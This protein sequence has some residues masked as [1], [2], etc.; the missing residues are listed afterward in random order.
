IMRALCTLCKSLLIC[1]TTSTVTSTHF[2]MI[3]RSVENGGREISQPPQL[4]PSVGLFQRWTEE[5]EG[6]EHIVTYSSFK[7]LSKQRAISRPARVFFDNGKCMFCPGSG[8]K[9]AQA[10]SALILPAAFAD[11]SIAKG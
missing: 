8:T 1:F 11:I 2:L 4:P 9:R 5:S 10:G 7:A 6:N 3:F